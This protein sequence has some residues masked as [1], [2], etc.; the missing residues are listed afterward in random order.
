MDDREMPKINIHGHL[1]RSQDIPK[2]VAIWDEWHVRHFCCLCL[3][4]DVYWNKGAG[5]FGNDDFLRIKG[6]YGDRILGFASVG[7]TRQRVGTAADVERYRDQGFVGLK[8]CDAGLPYN[9]ESLFPVYDRASELAM[10]V[11]FH[12]GYLAIGDP[13][14]DRRLG[15]ADENMH[16]AR[17]ATVARWFPD[18]K[19]VAAHLGTPNTAEAVN[20]LLAYEN[21]HCD[22]SGGSGSRAWV[23]GIL[24]ALLPPAG[25]ETDMADPAE[26]RALD[27]FT[28]LCFGTDNPEPSIWVPNSQLIMDRLEIPL[29]TRKLFYYDTAARLIGL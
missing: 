13:A 27:L 15:V 29:E 18:L 10:P 9:H 12:A 20:Q 24:G 4:E 19:I 22:F 28:K 14:G 26:N 2:R 3:N 7:A 8:F 1:L 11:V 17:L 23:R 16:V 6:E 21:F 25:L 5:Y